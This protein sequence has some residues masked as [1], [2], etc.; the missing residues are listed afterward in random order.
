MKGVFVAGVDTGVGK[1]VFSAALLKI[2]DGSYSGRYWKPIQTGTIVGDDTTSV[3][4]LTE[5]SE[6]HFLEPAYKFAEPLSPHVAAA[7]WGKRIDI[8]HIIKL[9]SDAMKTGTFLIVEGAGGL[10]VPLNESTLQIE[11][12]KKMNLPLILVSEDRV[13]AINQT[14]LSIRAAR[15]VGINVLGIVLTKSRRTFGNA[16]SISSFGKVDILLELDPTED[17][18]NALAQAAGDS[19]IRRCLG[20][21]EIPH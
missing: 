17:S 18:R 9:F 4:E 11:L 12:I 19:K 8:D 3:K 5:L 6:D 15:E 21:K 1:T 16:E 13:G 2:V 14:L 7:K 20:V 10:L